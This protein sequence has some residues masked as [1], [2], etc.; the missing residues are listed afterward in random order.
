MQCNTPEKL[1]PKSCLSLGLYK[2][3]NMT[4]TQKAGTLSLE[5]PFLRESNKL[6]F[7]KR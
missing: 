2:P 7:D 6:V 5:L 4:I 1:E 3:N